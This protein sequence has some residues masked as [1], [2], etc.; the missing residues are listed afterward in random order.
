MASAEGISMAMAAGTEAARQHSVQATSFDFPSVQQIFSEL[1]ESSSSLSDRGSETLSLEEHE[2]MFRALSLVIEN[3]ESAAESG[4]AFDLKE[5][6]ASLEQ[7]DA[8]AR[9]GRRDVESLQSVLEILNKLWASNSEFLVQAAEV[10]ANGSRELSWRGPIGK[11]GILKFFL[12]VI[13]SKKNVG[14]KLLYHSL[15]LVG[16]TCADMNENRQIVLEG[17]YTL[18]IIRHFLNPELVHVAI[19][20]IYNI[21]M[22][23]EPA[24]AQVAENRTA[25]IILKLLKDG[26]IK[27]NSALLNF[28][29]DLVELASEQAQG[30]DNSPDGT[31]WL[32]TQ[33]ALE[34]TEFDHFSSLVN[35]LTA[36]LDKE[37]FQ[38]ACVSNNMVEDVLSVLRRS[39][40]IE[41]D[42]TSKEEVSGIAQIRLKI[43]QA[44]GEVSASELFAEHYPL[45]SALA[46]TLKSW[47]IA[48]EEQL[49]IC[50]CVML[51][52]LARSDEVC[53]VMVRDLKIHVELVS[54]LESGSRGSVLHSVL[55]FLKNLAI[56]GDNRVSLAEAGI[57][58]AVSRL[59]AFESVPQVQFMAASIARQVTISSMENI[60]RLLAP[61]SEDPD[62]PAHKRTYLSLLLSLFEKTD[63][64]PIKTEIG[65]TVAS[66][67]RTVTPKAREGDE[68]AKSLLEKLYTLHE[69]VA[70][71]V[72]AMITQTQWPVVR[73]EG[74]FAL[75]LMASNHSGCVAVVN[76]LHNEEVAMLLKKT[77]DGE[78]S[79]SDA[80]DESSKP[81]E[82]QVTKDRD[83]VFVLVQELLKNE[84]GALPMGSRETLEGLV[85]TSS[86][87]LKGTQDA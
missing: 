73:S 45:D 75:A 79:A 78:V 6:H 36:Y 41:I 47:I 28:S 87:R 29:Y 48:D 53:Q 42:E 10:M 33:L 58:P 5:L 21:C 17:F 16:N 25:Y 14:V 24:H 49:Q 50:A 8:D 22:D 2:K 27:D 52:N 46:Q 12:D 67:C 38:N 19:P 83:N 43:N 68:A 39:F 71:P 57:I 80:S 76:C 7:A 40:S 61:L 56:A 15:R 63:S 60:A 62:S 11:S 55:G 59:W 4:N 26:V 1:P 35:S 70:R 54:V 72:G 31:I 34:E 74:W 3:A 69:G 77:L 18:P 44:L 86:L 37:R 65:R 51:G 82:T 20:V 85:K 64:A 9:R 23:Y 13:S 30:I 84:A 32:L 81:D 66:I